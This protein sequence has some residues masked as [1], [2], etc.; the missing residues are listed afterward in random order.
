MEIHATLRE[1]VQPT[2]SNMQLVPG[3]IAISTMQKQFKLSESMFQM[4]WA[5]STQVGCAANKCPDRSNGSKFTYVMICIYTPG[6]QERPYEDGSSCS[7]CPDNYGCDRNQCF[8]NATVSSSLSTAPAK[9]FSTTRTLT[10][11]ESDHI[12]TRPTRSMSLKTTSVSLA[13]SKLEVLL[14]F[15]FFV[16]CF[17]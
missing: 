7:R 16:F 5:T 13:P 3:K 17:L 6:V 15:A 8:K 12:G 10:T 11:M 2:A 14:F 9:T 1:E 4:V